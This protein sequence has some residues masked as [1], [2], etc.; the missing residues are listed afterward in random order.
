M[1]SPGWVDAPHSIRDFIFANQCAQE[2][3]HIFDVREWTMFEGFLYFRD[4]RASPVARCGLPTKKDRTGDIW[5]QG[6]FL[7]KFKFIN[8]VLAPKSSQIYSPSNYIPLSFS[9]VSSSLLYSYF[10]L[11]LI[12]H[13]VWS[14]HLILYFSALHCGVVSKMFEQ[15]WA[16]Q[17]AP[18]ASIATR[19]ATT[20]TTH[21]Y[22]T[23]CRPENGRG[24]PR[25][26]M[27]VYKRAPLHPLTNPSTC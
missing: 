14:Y 26:N 19:T 6:F 18:S 12:L 23:R 3:T 11:F 5:S 13:S 24:W 15:K 16:R 1:D 20:T 22:C 25:Y 21:V 9:D 27:I 4:S 10:M 17:Y 8:I 7:S 2:W